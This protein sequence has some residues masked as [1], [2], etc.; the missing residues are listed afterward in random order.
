[1]I[2]KSI[3]S[4]GLVV[5]LGFLLTSCALFKPSTIPIKQAGPQVIIN[6]FVTS[7]TDE[8]PFSKETVSRPLAE[9]RGAQ[10]FFQEMEGAGHL[11]GVRFGYRLTQAKPPQSLQSF[12]RKEPAAS[13]KARADQTVRPLPTPSLTVGRYVSSNPA[14]QPVFERKKD[15]LPAA[16]CSLETKGEKVVMF[17]GLIDGAA[18][19]A[20]RLLLKAGRRSFVLIS[21]KTAYGQRGRGKIEQF[22]EEMGMRAYTS[23]VSSGDEREIE[24]ILNQSRPLPILAW[25]DRERTETLVQASRKVSYPEPVILGPASVNPL[26]ASGGDRRVSYEDMMPPA[27]QSRQKIFAIGHRLAVADDLGSATGWRLRTT[28]MKENR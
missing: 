28:W 22:A 9:L 24:T 7:R 10:L 17:S 12:V 21:D 6:L 11:N 3:H 8:S 15:S 13:S 25:L 4:L 2:N 18:R 23:F 19:K 20:L 27:I 16:S 26:L 5:F 1:M 14:D